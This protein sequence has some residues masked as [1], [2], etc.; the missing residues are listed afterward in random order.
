MFLF[1]ILLNSEI[2]FLKDKQVTLRR[3]NFIYKSNCSCGESYIGQIKRNLTSRLKEHHPG[4][5][6]GTQT[7]VTKHLLENP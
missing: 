4:Y 2:F 3:S 7:D 6:I 1:T 5:K